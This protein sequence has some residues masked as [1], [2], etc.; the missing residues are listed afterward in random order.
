[1]TEH[2][3][4]VALCWRAR[5]LAM[6][7]T[8]PGGGPRRAAVRAPAERSHLHHRQHAGRAACSTT[9]GSRRCSTR[10]SRST[11]W[12]SATSASAATR[13]TTRLR[14]KNFGTPDEWL[15]GHRRR[16]S[17]ATRR[18]ASRAP[19]P[20]PTWSSRS[21]ATTSRSPAQAGLDAFKKQ[22]DDWIKHTLAQKYN[23]KI[24]AAPRRCSRRSRTRTSAIPI[25]P[26]ARRTTSACELYTQAMAEVAKAQRRDVRRS[27]RAQ[28]AAVRGDARR[29]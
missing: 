23:G 21:S 27:V 29:R 3:A 25:C 8:M 14:S 9:A 26:T 19:T 24:G 2:D 12:S 4:L 1:M 17:A 6:L 20:R 13:S 7:W 11:T 10:V 28:P 18:T 16:R 22:L 5:A 15:S